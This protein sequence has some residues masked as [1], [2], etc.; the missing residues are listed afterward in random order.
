MKAMILAAGEG[1]RMRPLTDVTPKPLLEV[2][3]TP[4]IEHH[5]ARL[6]AAGFTEIVVNVSY[7]G[8]QLVDFLGDGSQWQ[9]AIS[10]SAEQTPLETAGGIIQALPRLGDAPFLLVNGDVFTDYPFAQLRET[11]PAERGAHIVLAPNPAHRPRGDFLLSGR[12]VEALPL[13][14]E[15]LDASQDVSAKQTS[16]SEVNQSADTHCVSA[17]TQVSTSSVD[18][19]IATYSGIGVYDPVMF[20][21]CAPGKRP[22]KPLLDAAIYSGSLS[23]ELYEGVWEDVG[24]PERLTALNRRFPSDSANQ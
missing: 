17:L 1:R 15:H 2:G 5:I 11:A 4:L 10:I 13:G 8:Q 19:N 16:L 21:D 20:Q 14:A 7:L 18:S 6:S 3:G 23:G 24:T 22:L 9:V 12:S